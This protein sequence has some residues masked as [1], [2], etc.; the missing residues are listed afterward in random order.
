MSEGRNAFKL[1]V[2]TQWNPSF[3]RPY[4]R[5]DCYER[6]VKI[7]EFHFEKKSCLLLITGYYVP[8]SHQN[9][10]I[11]LHL[12]PTPFLDS[13]NT[14]LPPSIPWSKRSNIPQHREIG[15]NTIPVMYLVSW[16]LLNDSNNTGSMKV[17]LLSFVTT[18]FSFCSNFYLMTVMVQCC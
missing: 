13:P 18:A 15:S 17:S 7:N 12:V 16:H 6:Y 1:F 11:S 5:N 4:Y 10:R 14:R 2:Q 3:I 8:S 9:Q